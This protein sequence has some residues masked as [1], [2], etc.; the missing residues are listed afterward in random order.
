MI[1]IGLLSGW[2][3]HAKGY[4]REL[5]SSNRVEISGIWD[6]L[7]D[8]GSAWAQELDTVFYTD[9]DDLLN[10]GID[11]VVI[12]V[13]TNMHREIM[14]KA[15]KAKKHIFT[16]KVLT[17]KIEDALAI[18][19]YVVDSGVKF[20]ISLPHRTMPKN[21]YAKEIVESGLLGEISLFRVRNAHSGASDN[22]L[23]AHF[24]SKEQCGGGAM[25]DL[26]AHP[27][28]LAR[29]LM[30][31]PE[32]VYSAFTFVTGHEVEDNAVT[33][34]KYKNGAV[35][36]VETGFVTPAS[37]FSMEIYGTKGTLFVDGKDQG[38]LQ[39]GRLAE[40]DKKISGWFRPSTMP[41]PLKSA[42]YQWLDAIEFNE[43]IE[44]GI[45][46]A[47]ELTEMMD[48]A[49]AAHDANSELEF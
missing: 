8:R 29:W 30:G 47:V 23:P 40:T 22:W 24:Y 16:E 13:P 43:P 49:Y 31:K 42:V 17:D 2:H 12:N 21:L 46:D 6:E 32:K 14:I 25:I 34:F 1:K 38:V 15:A 45:K 26:G 33:V 19:K 36:I 39:S 5:L 10:S 18:Q 41:K 7:P 3:V 11:G 9:M 27:M 4:A 28:Y 20:V 44:F 48:R 35:S 37:P